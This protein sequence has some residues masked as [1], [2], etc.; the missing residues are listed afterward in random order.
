MI[1]TVMQVCNLF[2]MVRI[3]GCFLFS[4]LE[5]HRMITFDFV[6]LI[7]IGGLLVKACLYMS[8]SPANLVF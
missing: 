7:W 6:I 2:F 5:G 3:I 4:F 8:P 1:I